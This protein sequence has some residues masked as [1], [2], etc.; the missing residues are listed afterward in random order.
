MSDTYKVNY[1]GLFRCCIQS[2]D[3]ALTRNIGMLAH[4]CQYCG[5]PMRLDVDVWR[6]DQELAL[7]SPEKPSE[8]T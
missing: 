7:S 1:G 4:R 8:Q 2:L 3:V 6:W 5:N